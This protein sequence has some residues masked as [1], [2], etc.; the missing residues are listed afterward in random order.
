MR[1]DWC[2]FFME[3][4]FKLID[5]FSSENGRSLV[6]RPA[7]KG[8]GIEVTN[9]FPDFQAPTNPVLQRLQTLRPLSPAESNASALRGERSVAGGSLIQEH[10][11]KG[12]FEEHRYG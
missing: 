7:R 9:P 4:K 1:R 2:A 5:R 8:D 6:G 12:P 11:L 3:I 10:E